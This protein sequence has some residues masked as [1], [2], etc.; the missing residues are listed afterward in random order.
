MKSE[1]EHPSV[2]AEH[3]N[4]EGYVW[5][6]ASSLSDLRLCLLALTEFVPVHAESYWKT[7]FSGCVYL[8]ILV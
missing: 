3:A 7:F 6:T 5:L 8:R 2:T 4:L 1:N